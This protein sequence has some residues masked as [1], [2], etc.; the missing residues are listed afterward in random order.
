[1]AAAEIPL[2]FMEAEAP[3]SLP[4]LSLYLVAVTRACSQHVQLRMAAEQTEGTQ[5][6][7]FPHVHVIPTHLEPQTYDLY[8]CQ[9]TSP[10]M[11]PIL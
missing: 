9:G 10:S 6:N 5:P 7:K 4:L 8:L 1:M 11:S 2:C 3:F